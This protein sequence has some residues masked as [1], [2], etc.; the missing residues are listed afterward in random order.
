MFK[1]ASL[2][3]TVYSAIV[4]PLFLCNA[5]TIAHLKFKVQLSVEGT[6]NRTKIETKKA[7]IPRMRTTTLIDFIRSLN[8][9]L[10]EIDNHPADDLASLH[11]IDDVVDFA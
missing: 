4:K 1:S 5:L 6:L 11:F 10:S 2:S 9:F 7:V 3:V 8:L